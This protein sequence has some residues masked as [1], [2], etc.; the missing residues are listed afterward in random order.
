MDRLHGTY[1]EYVSVPAGQLFALGPSLPTEEAILVEPLAVVVHAFRVSMSA[2]PPRSMAIFGAG[3]LGCLALVLAR[4]RGVPRIAVVDNNERRLAVARKL[5]ADLATGGPKAA[6]AVRDF[7]DGRGADH[8]VEAIGLPATRRAAVEATAAGGRLLFLGLAEND[9]SLPFIEMTRK[10]QAIFTSFAYAPRDFE[11]AVKLVEARAF[12]FK[13]WTET[14]PLA[15]GQAG[16]EKMVR[17]PGETLKLM[18]SVSE[19]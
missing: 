14:L 2:D 8:V 12:D 19:A 4:R 7:F 3:P 11:A 17:N 13:P 16:F 5:G 10:E 1:A 9:S 18:L 6:A 15:S